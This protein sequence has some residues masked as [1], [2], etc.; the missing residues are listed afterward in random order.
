MLSGHRSMAAWYFMFSICL[1][2]VS[3]SM[4]LGSVVGGVR[5]PQLSR[6]CQRARS[7]RTGGASRGAQA[8]PLPI[9]LA[10]SRAPPRQMPAPIDRPPVTSQ[11]SG[12]GTIF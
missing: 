1:V 12:R 5:L 7:Y 9:S 4:S 3:L 10:G 8:G 6:P 2:S 11:K